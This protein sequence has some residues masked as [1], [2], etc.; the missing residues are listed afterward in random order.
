MQVEETHMLAVG[1]KRKT[2]IDVIF[3]H[4]ILIGRL[5]HNNYNSGIIY[6]HHTIHVGVQI[7]HAEEAS[8]VWI[9]GVFCLLCAAQTS[10][11]LHEKHYIVFFWESKQKAPLF[12]YKRKKKPNEIRKVCFSPTFANESQTNKERKQPLN[13]LIYLSASLGLIMAEMRYYFCCGPLNQHFNTSFNI[14]K[15]SDRLIAFF[16]YWFG[17]F[18][19]FYRTKIPPKSNKQRYWLNWLY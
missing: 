16:P 19:G 14:Y 1:V 10:K 7:A 15:S 12:W 11:K 18:A 8:L 13:T 3:V 4:I 5:Q 2:Q 6:F 17:V 9:A